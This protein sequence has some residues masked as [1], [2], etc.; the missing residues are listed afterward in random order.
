MDLTDESE[1]ALLASAIRTGVGSRGRTFLLAEDDVWVAPKGG[2]DTPR[3]FS[4]HH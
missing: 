2:A 1:F 4:V 3:G